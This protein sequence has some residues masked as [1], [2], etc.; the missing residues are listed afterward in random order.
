MRERKVFCIWV[1]LTFLN[2]IVSSSFSYSHSDI[3]LAISG[4]HIYYIDIDS[5]QYNIDVNTNVI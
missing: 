3:S 5:Y 1:N 4:G 2:G